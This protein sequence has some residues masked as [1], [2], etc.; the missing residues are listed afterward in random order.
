MKEKTRRK[1]LLLAAGLAASI[2]NQAR[3]LESTD[4]LL[5]NKGPVSVRPQLNVTESLNDNVFY[6]DGGRVKREGDFLSG[7]SPGLNLL[8]GQ[9]PAN[10]MLL[11][12]MHDQFFY[13]EHPE[14]DAGQHRGSLSSHFEYHRFTIVG[15]DRTELLN[16]VLGGSFQLRQNVTRL[17]NFHDYRVGYELSEKTSLYVDGLFSGVDYLPPFADN[18]LDSRTLIGTLGFSYK[19][20]S[21]TSFFGEV[22]YGQTTTTPNISSLKL[23]YAEFTGGFLGA[24]GEFTPHLTGQVKAG[25]EVRSF[26][27]GTPGG[28]SPVVSASLVQAFT[29][30]RSL[31]FNYS[32][33]Q[34]VSVQY[35][36]ESYV[37]DSTSLVL[38]QMLG[39][40][41]RWRASAELGYDRI[42]Y[43]ENLAF[44]NRQDTDFRISTVLN[45]QVRRWLLAGLTYNFE[46]FTSDLP[47]V[48][49]YHVNRVTLSLAIGF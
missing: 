24:K 18:L 6:G 42:S 47:V 28:N 25:Y 23:P 21:K 9:D 46:R 45:Y 19:A 37:I 13:V 31:S 38:S 14:L 10:S 3:A 22:Y 49:D 27:D 20:F 41:R 11:T 26:S 39:E 8:V 36:R 35:I 32:R 17:V 34:E 2:P 48:I 44:P 33:R 7:I 40:T 12:Y 15:T 4:F 1:Y 5:F 30:K 16:S 29:E 43:D